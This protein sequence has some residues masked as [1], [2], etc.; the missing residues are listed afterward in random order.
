MDR[1]HEPASAV[2]EHEP[3]PGARG[4]SRAEGDRSPQ[5]EPAP[6]AVTSFEAF[7]EAEHGRLLRAMYIVTGNAQE[8]EE[9]MQDAF[10]AVWERWDRVG[11]MDEPTGYLYRT[12]MNRFRSRLRRAARATRRVVGAAEGRDAFAAAE[13]RDA[14]ARALA[15]LPERQRAAI[16]LTELLGYDS[17]EAGRILGVKDV[18]IRSLASQAR[19]ALRRELEDRDE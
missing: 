19:A 12:A 3:G 5:D 11:A 8:A 7:F 16:V 9:L 18:T 10:V 13:E 14:V 6:S 17:T 4:T 2:S 1:M 15:R